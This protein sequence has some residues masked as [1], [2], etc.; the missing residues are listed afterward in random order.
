[1][2]FKNLRDFM[3]RWSQHQPYLEQSNKRPRLDDEGK[4]HGHEYELND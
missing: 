4:I 2:P 3:Y 1:M